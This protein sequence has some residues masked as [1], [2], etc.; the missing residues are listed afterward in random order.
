MAKASK[1][2]SMHGFNLATMAT[3]LVL[4]C[5]SHTE[6]AHAAHPSPLERRPHQPQAEDSDA[7][8]HAW[9]TPGDAMWGYAGMVG[10]LMTSSQLQFVAKT[11]KVKKAFAMDGE[12]ARGELVC[13][14]HSLPT[15]DQEPASMHSPNMLSLLLS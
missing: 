8:G 1:H 14:V 7:W 6:A 13:N 4:G 15:T 12:L 11:Y 3:V 10:Q 5:S 2:H 9:D